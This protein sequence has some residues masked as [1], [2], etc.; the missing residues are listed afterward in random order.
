MS[1]MRKFVG[2]GEVRYLDRPVD[3]T[4]GPDAPRVF[5]AVPLERN[6]QDNAV[7]SLLD[8][9]M[10]CGMRGYSH[11]RF[12]YARTDLARNNI[13]QMFLS[14]TTNP[15]DVLVMVDNDHLV[16]ADLV[17]RL[18]RHNVPVVGALAFRRGE[19]YFPCFF[20]RPEGST[21][22]YGV[23]SEWEEGLLPVALVGTGAIAIRRHVFTDLDEA[24]FSWPYFR[25]Q[26]LP[27]DKTLPS[28]DVYFA[29]ACE[30][31][32]IQQYV[33]TTFCIPHLAVATID[34]WDFEQYKL[35]NPKFARGE[36]SADEIMRPGDAK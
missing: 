19:P 27:G 7:T 13:V 26:Y 23:V 9:A 10:W 28:E 16:P 36:M 35:R 32:G 14:Q 12:P 20:V 18:I 25:Y 22:T 11:I 4:P 24:G 21:D 6:T 15:Q 29:Q 31:A 3:Y 17:D 30:S 8:M 1:T 33:D 34:A 2:D 5:W